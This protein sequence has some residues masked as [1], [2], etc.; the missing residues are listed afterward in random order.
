MTGFAWLTLLPFLL[1]ASSGD[2]KARAREADLRKLDEWIDLERSFTD[3]RRRE[4]HSAVAAHLDQG[5]QF[6]DSELD[7][8]VRRIVALAD[9]GHSN[10][11]VDP[12]FER[13]G[14]LPLRT[15]WFSDGLY[16]VR[17]REPQRKLLGARIVSVEGR[18]IGELETRLKAYCGGTVEYFR[19]NAEALLLL[20]PALMHAVGLAEHADR[21]RLGVV[22]GKGESVE[23][24]VEVD[25][26]SSALRAQPWRYLSPVP[27]EGGEDWATAR[28]KDAELPLWLQQE[29]EGFRYV[30]LA[31]GVAYLQLRGNHDFGS[32]RIRDF[33]ARTEERLQQDQPRS[34]VLDDRENGGGDLTTTADFAL[35]LPS[36]VQPG[37]RVY[38]LT[39]NGTF[40]AGI[41]TSFYPK[42]S[43]P[44]HT[45]V[46]GELV[47]DRSEFWAEIGDPFQLP[48]CGLGIGYA[49]QRH[50]V[51]HGC[52][53]SPECHMA[54]YAAEWN[55]VVDTL[56]PDWPVP[57]TFA[58]FAAGRDPVLERVLQ[59]ET[60]QR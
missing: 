21:L 60:G 13:F 16:V 28:A 10:A 57:M 32:K 51:V 35:E 4:A 59:A 11:D 20:S 6:T 40:S 39:G 44:E 7:M 14:L 48:E 55:L 30:L 31:N 23:A 50:D 56:E 37:G 42:A 34:I 19:Y 46:V 29:A 9:N 27:I 17:A 49:L 2:E 43:D 36:F 8:E 25:Q 12:I 15:Y 58:D 54:Q 1:P 22:N 18:P 5:K 45:L 52:T 53:V 26:G 3:E 24:I 38:V 47:G 33:A 41:Y